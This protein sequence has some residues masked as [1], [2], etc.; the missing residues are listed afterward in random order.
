[1]N[2]TDLS[3]E[4]DIVGTDVGDVW[5]STSVYDFGGSVGTIDALYTI[6][7]ST[8]A[9][10][11]FDFVPGEADR[12]DDARV[13]FSNI[14]ASPFN[15]H[16]RI[17]IAFVDPDNSDS[18]VSFSAADLYIQFDDLDSVPGSDL[19]DYAGVYDT[20]FDQVTLSPDTLLLENTTFVPGATIGVL[21]GDGVGL[22]YDSAPNMIG[23]D[24]ETQSPVTIGFQ[25]APASAAVGSFDFIVGVTGTVPGSRHIDIDM[26]PDF[27]I[28]PEPSSVGLLGLSLSILLLRRRRR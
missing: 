13:R 26:T 3:L 9:E 10:N 28:I 5:R 18:A 19:A 8:L 15:E 6:I 17:N 22:P 20:D 14:S 21:E 12:G 1:M 27:Q 23:T 25:I 7:S 4:T 16:V 11:Q 24:A 2:F